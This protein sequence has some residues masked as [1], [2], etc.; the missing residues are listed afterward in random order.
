[1]IKESEVKPILLLAAGG[2]LLYFV[3]KTGKSITDLLGITKSKEETAATNLSTALPSENPFNSNYWQLLSKK[4][5]VYIIK[6]KDAAYYNK[7]IR[8]SIS[9]LPTLTD[10]GKINNVFKSLKYK[11]QVSYLCYKFSQKYKDNLFTYIKSG[12]KL[13]IGNTGISEKELFD[14]INYVNK[15]PNGLK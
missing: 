10:A 1:M 11:S 3:T 8:D 13:P 12:Y 9:M 2:I 15:L 4:G 5:K 7:I 6:E 14:I